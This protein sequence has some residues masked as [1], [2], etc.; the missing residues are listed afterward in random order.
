MENKTN[1]RKSLYITYIALFIVITTAACKNNIST[2][3]PEQMQATVQSMALTQIASTAQADQPIADP[4]LT[5]PT[6]PTNPTPTVEV[7]KDLFVLVTHSQSDPTLA[8]Y[9]VTKIEQLAT[10]VNAESQALQTIP[11]TNQTIKMAVFLFPAENLN[12]FSETHPSTQIVAIGY[13]NITP[14]ANIIEISAQNSAIETNFAA[15]LL[16]AMAAENW[17]TAIIT[18]ENETAK[19]NAFIKGAKA[20]CGVCSPPENES[21]QYPLYYTLTSATTSTDLQEIIYQ[22]RLHY[23][24]V[25]Y[26]TNNVIS[27]DIEN[28][29]LQNGFRIAGESNKSVNLQNW[30]FTFETTITPEILENIFT[31]IMLGSPTD[32]HNYLSITVIDSQAVSTGKINKMEELLEDLKSGFFNID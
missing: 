20:F 8:N 30:I 21:L 15:G 2:L 23:I 24:D 26:L 11:N 27:P 31:Q 12:M 17:R 13:Q 14:K 10:Q 3:T 1:F 28:E 22:L 16:S 6:Q 32:H 5:N 7:E 4:Q 25:V 9:L 29:L 18:L 19:A